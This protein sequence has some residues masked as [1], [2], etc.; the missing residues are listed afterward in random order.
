MIGFN[1]ETV[2]YFFI[3]ICF[4]MMV[5]NIVYIF[6]DHMKEKSIKRRQLRYEKQI[7]WQI[8]LIQMHAPLDSVHVRNVER[9]LRYL[10]NL[11]AFHDACVSLHKQKENIYWYIQEMA[12]IFQNLIMKYERRNDMDKAYLA[13]VIGDLFSEHVEQYEHLSRLLLN[14]LE[15]TTIYCRENT[16]SALY[17][18]GNPKMIERAYQMLQDN[19][20]VHHEKLLSDGL[21]KYTGDHE[22]LAYLLWR[23]YGEWNS[24]LMLPIINYIRYVSDD[25][26]ALFLPVLQNEEEDIEIRL[27]ILRYYRRYYYAPVKEILIAYALQEKSVDLAILASAALTNYPGD[28]SIVALKKALCHKDWYVRKNAAQSLVSIANADAYQDVFAG[29]DTYAKDMLTYVLKQREVDG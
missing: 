12:P 23:H 10:D 19:H 15:N 9:Q 16:L 3:F 6:Q 22:E 17:K 11:I 28:D 7:Y 8:G 18:L 21:L 2:I 14:Y 26:T 13:W 5:F 20:N 27:A 4:S 29:T 24:E 1:V 25:F